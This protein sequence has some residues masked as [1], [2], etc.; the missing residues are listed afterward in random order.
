[1]DIEALE[2][3]LSSIKV[4]QSSGDECEVSIAGRLYLVAEGEVSLLEKAARMP[5]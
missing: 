5:E 2:E 4:L 1:V 3:R